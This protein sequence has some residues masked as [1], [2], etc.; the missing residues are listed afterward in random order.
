V[1]IQGVRLTD[2]E[3]AVLR[4]LPSHMTNE[5]ISEALFLSVNTVKT[6]LRPTGSWASGPGGTR[7][8][9]G[10]VSA[11]CY[12]AAAALATWRRYSRVITSSNP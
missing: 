1:L 5:E 8:P 9:A 3:H 10:A 6:H 12:L 7:S 4:F 2:S 11:C